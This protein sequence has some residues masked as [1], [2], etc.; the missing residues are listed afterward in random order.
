MFVSWAVYVP[1]S[2]GLCPAP[3]CDPLGGAIPAARLMP[4]ED[5]CVG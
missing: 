1:V 5:Q 3:P 4:E 2:R